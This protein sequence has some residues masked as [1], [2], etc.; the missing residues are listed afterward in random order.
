MMEQEMKKETSKVT[1]TLPTVSELQQR[2][3]DLGILSKEILDAFVLLNNECLEI[4]SLCQAILTQIEKDG[5]KQDK[6]FV[7]SI[8]S[9]HNTWS[10]VL[11]IMNNKEVLNKAYVESKKIR[12]ST[13]TKRFWLW[14][15]NND[16]D[17]DIAYI[18]KRSERAIEAPINN[19]R[20]GRRW[21]ETPFRDYHMDDDLAQVP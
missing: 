10:E 13:P 17:E 4:T 1:T 2:N 14:K 21:K 3:H 12:L 20:S 8:E 6:E 5:S 9:L 7:K 19:K 15:R 11:N 16:T 18:P